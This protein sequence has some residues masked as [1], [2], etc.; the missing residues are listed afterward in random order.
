[1]KL[2]QNQ[3]LNEVSGKNLIEN[4]EN[5]WESRTSSRTSSKIKNL[6]KNL[7]KN[8]DLG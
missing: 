1:M 7:I 3:E 8:Q 5:H 4:Q 2:L 6:T